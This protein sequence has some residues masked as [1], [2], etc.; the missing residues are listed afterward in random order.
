MLAVIEA[1]SP[2][3]RVEGPTEIFGTERPGET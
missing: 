2:S 3:K 1:F